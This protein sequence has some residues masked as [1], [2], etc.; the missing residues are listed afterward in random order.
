[1]SVRAVPSIP[2]IAPKSNLDDLVNIKQYILNTHV[3]LTGA[4]DKELKNL[5]DIKDDIKIRQGIVD[6]I[7]KADKIKLDADT[8]SQKIKADADA[9][10]VE[11]G[12]DIQTN[13]DKANALMV[14][15]NLRL[16]EAVTKENFINNDLA[17]R[18]L[19]LQTDINMFEQN[20]EITTLEWQKNND[21]FISSTKQK[22]DSLVTREKNLAAGQL[23]LSADRSAFIEEQKKFQAKIDAIM[24]A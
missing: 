12:I 20:K 19:K 16:N 7:T 18:Q 8:Y 21:D 10:A 23:Q 3:L 11:K 24:K 2:E 13:Y 9:Y 14:S 1:M 6:T 4:F 22:N 5:Q 17:K 15:A